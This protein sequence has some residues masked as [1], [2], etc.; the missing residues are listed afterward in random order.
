MMP[1]L[2]RHGIQLQAMTGA[3]PESTDDDYAVPTT[4]EHA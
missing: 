2:Q 1:V 3:V 4:V